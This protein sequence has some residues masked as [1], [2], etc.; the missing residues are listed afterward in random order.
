MELDHGS[1]KALLDRRREALHYFD[2]ARE[3]AMNLAL[4][5]FPERCC[6]NQTFLHLQYATLIN[7]RLTL[8]GFTADA[9]ARGHA[10]AGFLGTFSH[11][12]VLRGVVKGSRSLHAAAQAARGLASGALRSTFTGHKHNVDKADDRGGVEK[13]RVMVEARVSQ[14]QSRTSTYGLWMR[15]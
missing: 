5:Q 12:C 10:L 14:G 2:P 7:A 15:L 3:A 11:L 13:H 6:F 4:R 8:V 1:P 9:N